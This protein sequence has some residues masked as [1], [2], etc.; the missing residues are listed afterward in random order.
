MTIKNYKNHQSGKT[1]LNRKIK[2]IKINVQAVSPYEY[3]LHKF[4]LDNKLIFTNNTLVFKQNP[5]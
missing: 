4:T 2:S 1:F 5:S 3:A